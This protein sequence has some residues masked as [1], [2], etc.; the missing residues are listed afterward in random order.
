MLLQD[1]HSSV[2]ERFLGSL[3]HGEKHTMKTGKQ[4]NVSSLLCKGTLTLES[5]YKHVPD[6]AARCTLSVAFTRLFQDNFPAL[7]TKAM[8][9][10]MLR[11]RSAVDMTLEMLPP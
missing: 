10:A 2:K 3:S 11:C 1:F 7:K 4:S 9:T 5:M 8:A 6:R